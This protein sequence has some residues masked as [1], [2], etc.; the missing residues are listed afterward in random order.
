MLRI[1]FLKLICDQFYFFYVYS[2]ESIWYSFNDY[3]NKKGLFVSYG[4]VVIM[5]QKVKQSKR[6]FK[7][8]SY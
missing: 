3:S 1:V 6:S 5:R 8:K 4:N 7:I 2:L